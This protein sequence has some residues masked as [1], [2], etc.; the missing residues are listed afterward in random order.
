MSNSALYPILQVSI[1][2]RVAANIIGL[3]PLLMSGTCNAY[4]LGRPIA[5][6]CDARKMSFPFNLSLITSVVNV[7]YV[8]AFAVVF[9]YGQRIQLSVMQ[10]GVK[11]Q[12][13][14]LERMQSAARARF[15][16]S[17]KKF[18]GEQNLDQSVDRLLGSFVIS[19]VDMDPSG[20]VPKMEHVLDNA[21]DNL[22]SEVR[23]M[24]PHAS[25]SEVQTLSNEAEVAIG[26]NNMFKVA[27]HY[28]IL[29]TK[30]GGTYSLVQ[31]QMLMPQMM[32]IADAYNSA[33]DAFVGGKTLGDG[34]GP[35]VAAELVKPS[36]T[37]WTETVKDTEVAKVNFENHTAYVVKAKGPGGN[38]GKPGEAIQKILVDDPSVKCVLTVDASLKLEGED[39]GSTA[40]GV[41]AAIGGPG[42]DRF[43]IEESAS[44]RNIKMLAIVAKM[45]EKEAITEIPKAVR[46]KVPTTVERIRHIVQDMPEGS[47]VIIAGIGN[48]LGVA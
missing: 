2:E 20:I 39:T 7:L 36:T 26:L 4:M 41:G 22:R 42:V 37:T 18:G 43:R 46:E 24:A 13:A 25:E 35:L 28:Y 6:L 31:L 9:L 16:D 12:I 10:R 29:G 15:V 34:F 44:T 14:K 47:S 32:E 5:L 21:D 8:G 48:T 23:R 17:L 45:S 19:P 11:G 38:V 40:E 3:M 27:R 1:V 33:M 30:A